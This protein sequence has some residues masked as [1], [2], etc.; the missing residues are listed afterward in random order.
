MTRYSV[1]G[2]ARELSPAEVEIVRSVIASLKDVT[3][4]TT[5]AAVGVDTT[6]HYVARLEH[7]NAYHR[8]CIPAAPHN[9]SLYKDDEN[10]RVILEYAPKGRSRSESYMLRNDRVVA[11]ADILL[12]FPETSSEELRSGTWATVRRALNAGIGVQITPL[13]SKGLLRGRARRH[14]RPSPGN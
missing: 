10:S 8:L 1:T 9:A 13:R 7:P 14:R 6:A 3:E 11:H 2:R 12:A 5:G 4:F